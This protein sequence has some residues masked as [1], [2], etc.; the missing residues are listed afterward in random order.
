MAE[1]FLRVNL[2]ESDVEALALILERTKNL[3]LDAKKLLP[4]DK[5][6]HILEGWT[7]L[8]LRGQISSDLSG[9]SGYNVDVGAS[10]ADQTA[11]EDAAASS[12]ADLKSE[13]Q[14]TVSS[15]T[16]KKQS[17]D[18][19]Q[20]SAQN[21][22]VGGNDDTDFQTPRD[23]AD[24][25]KGQHDTGPREDGLLEN[26]LF[27][28]QPPVNF[29][30]L[31]R[32]NGHERDERLAFVAD[33]HT[34]FLDGSHKFNVSVTGVCGN[35]G[36]DFKT[37]L[38]IHRMVSSKNWPRDDYMIDDDGDMRPMTKQEIKAKWD[39]GRD[40]AGNRGTYMHSL[41][42]WLLTDPRTMMYV[43]EIKMFFN[44]YEAYLTNTTPYRLE[45]RIFDEDLDIAGSVDFVGKN[46]DGTF[47]LVDWKRSKEIKFEAYNNK[48]MKEPFSMLP[49]SNFG[50]FSLQLNLY[51]MLLE[52]NYGLIVSKMMIAVF[53]PSCNEVITVEDLKLGVVEGTTDI[54]PFTSSVEPSDVAGLLE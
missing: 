53:H 32:K 5:A 43:A 51:K 17:S 37:D 16:A 19:E 44:F 23:H 50:K 54:L 48:K 41:I 40:D 47:C 35:F 36:E 34:Y 46:A 25:Q 28:P 7:Q 2:G 10:K 29:D 13:Q 15:S 27:D 8:A 39:F 11:V 14:A 31:A 1:R 9:G 42:E 6:D 3:L 4:S 26:G 18:G 20:P 33:S 24:D 12:A 45:W 49:D 30:Y 52:K 22:S 21:L 38:I